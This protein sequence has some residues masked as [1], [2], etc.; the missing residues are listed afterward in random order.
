MTLRLRAQWVLPITGPPIGNG[1]VVVEAGRIAAVRPAPPAVPDARDLG[2]AILMPGLVNAHT[3]LD[4]T[5]MRGALEDRPFFAWVR[6]LVACKT[7]LD[8]EDWLASATFGA[9]EAVAG[10]ITTVG[11]CTDSGAALHAAIALGLSGVIYQEVFGIDESRTV[12]AIMTELRG[13]VERMQSDATGTALTIGISPHAPYTVRPALFRALADYAR[14]AQ[15][16]L[17]IHAAES[18]AEQE[19]LQ[20]GAGPIARMF[21]RRGIAWQAPGV[22]TIAYLDA[23]GVL[24]PHTLLVHGVQVTEADRALWRE[25][26]AAWAHCPKSNAKLGNGVAPLTLLAG[27]DDPTD[28]PRVGLG[29]DS[30]ASNNTM[31][32]FEEM[33]VAVLLQR[34][35]QQDVG[36]LTAREIVEMATLGGARALGMDAQAGS[37]EPGKRADLCAVCPGALHGVPVYDPYSTLVYTARASDVMLTMIGGEIRYDATRGNRIEDRFPHLDL[38]PIRRRLDVAARKIRAR[39]PFDT[40]VTS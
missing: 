2:N 39:Y 23:Q 28:C 4:Y 19:L 31:D 35:V 6:A 33:R 40:E 25:R 13:K 21:A 7:V 38:R 32:L 16:P 37:L 8:P 17:C 22:S 29:S 20:A 3:H 15:L 27:R 9:A 24:G 12:D 18:R 30:V 10:G 36:A 11:D 14:G 5:V 34:A 26:G 1:E